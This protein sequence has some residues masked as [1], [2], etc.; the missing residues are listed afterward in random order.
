MY[1]Y[2]ILND[3]PNILIFLYFCSNY[4]PF[5]MFNSDSEADSESWSNVSAT[6]CSSLIA[7]FYHGNYFL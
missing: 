5:N 4:F 6:S 3:V 1:H 2:T 7:F